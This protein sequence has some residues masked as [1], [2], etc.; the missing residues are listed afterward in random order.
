MV[1]GGYSQGAV[2]AGFITSAVAPRKH[3]RSSKFASY[4]PQPLPP[5]VADHVAAVVCSEHLT[6]SPLYA[7]KTIQLSP[8]RTIFATARLLDRP[9][10]P[11][12][13]MR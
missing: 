9:A 5:A 11:T 12:L 6:I 3:R 10:S 4:I 1:L 13:S 7:A 8:P 2:V